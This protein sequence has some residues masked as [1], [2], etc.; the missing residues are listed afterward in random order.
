[1]HRRVWMY[2]VF[3]S[4]LGMAA[5]SS[6]R[7]ETAPAPAAAPAAP[8][9]LAPPPAVP[10]PARPSPTTP[11]ARLAA[12]EPAEIQA[13]MVELSLAHALDVCGFPTLGQYMRDMTQQKVE[14]CPN[15]DARK[16]ALRDVVA[17]AALHEKRL[18]EQAGAQ[19]RLPRC[20]EA[21]RLKLIKEM[22]PVAQRVVAAADS[23]STAAASAAPSLRG[24]IDAARPSTRRSAPAQD[25]ATGRRASSLDA[26]KKILILSV[27]PEPREG[28]TVEGRTIAMQ[29]AMWLEG[30][31]RSREG[32]A[33]PASAARAWRFRS[34][35]SR[36][37]FLRRIDFGVTSTNSSSA[38]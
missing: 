4:L 27:R 26:T 23:R 38:M 37:R 21:D 10:P 33:Q 20:E 1:M 16:A 17:S 28:R 34:L 32:P 11:D 25:E 5:C 12:I 13:V 19:G 18:A 9:A 36:K 24:C 8:T 6:L 14:S 30:H 15:S 3:C 31:P 7:T 35:G 2:A 22:I 29:S